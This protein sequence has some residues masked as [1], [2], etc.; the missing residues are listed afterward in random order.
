M[1]GQKVEVK[2]ED[3]DMDKDFN[4]ADLDKCTVTM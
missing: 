3:A 2:S 1:K 4:L